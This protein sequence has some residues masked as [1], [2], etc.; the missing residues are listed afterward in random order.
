MNRTHDNKFVVEL[1][2]P[3]SYDDD[4][5]VIQWAVGIIPSNSLAALNGLALDAAKRHLLGPDVQ[6]EINTRQ[7]SVHHIPVKKIIHNIKQ[8]RYGGVVCLVGVMCHHLPR[9]MDLAK[10]FR[11]EN[12]QVIIG[13]AFVSS[14]IATSGADYKAIKELTE[15]GLSVFAGE[16]EDGRF[17]LVLQDAFKTNLARVYNYAGQTT[18][19]QNAPIPYLS[20]RFLSRFYHHVSID[21]GRGCPFKCDFCSIIHIHGHQSRS[22]SVGAIEEILRNYIKSGIKTFFIA[23]DNFSRNRNWEKILDHIIHLRETEN[24]DFTMTFQVDIQSATI[25]RFVDKAVRA[26][27]RWVFIGLESF[28]PANLQ[29]T[30][31]KINRVDKFYELLMAW[32]EKGVEAVIGYIL[33]FPND[34]FESIQEDIKRMHE[35]I[36]VDLILYNIMT[37]HPG[38]TLYKKLLNDG[39]KL[40][41]DY[42]RYDGEHPT[43]SMKNMS[44][45]ELQDSFHWAL[46]WWYAPEQLN[47]K[48]HLAHKDNLEVKDL[49]R[50]VLQFYALYRYGK[51]SSITIGF[52]RRKKQTSRRPG[53]PKENRFIFLIHRIRELW[54]DHYFLFSYS[55]KLRKQ[56]IRLLK[57]LDCNEKQAI[58][59][60]R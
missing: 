35:A 10:L 28:N 33:G 50:R 6:F 48:M 47:K 30:N 39:V 16:A 22:R 60:P 20:K 2:H 49:F 34:S 38:T 17:D 12:I 40:E 54:S 59:E 8:A 46:N 41:S 42:N 31:K 14:V 37:P 3:S 27:C 23:D 45:G 5:Y 11:M 9:A 21:F 25:P 56:R 4:G 18:D 43:I 26:G 44:A 53:F 57:E 7:E 24:L 32:R 15:L 29:E 58:K 1:I 13:G 52:I 51:G 36:P 55:W 19:L